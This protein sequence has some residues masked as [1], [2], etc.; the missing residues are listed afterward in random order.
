MAVARLA[1]HGDPQVVLIG[2][3][4]SLAA[5]ESAWMLLD[6]GYDV[7][8]FT[9]SGTRPAIGRDHRITIRPITSPQDDARTAVA[10]LIALAERVTPS[11]VLPLDDD[12][13]V[14]LTGSDRCRFQEGERAK[15]A[16]GTSYSAARASAG[17][18]ATLEATATTFASRP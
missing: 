1:Q 10:D 18:P 6:A 7:I 14:R 8:A 15:T 9:R 11:A 17:T 16:L 4:E 3:A 2:F 5:I 12:A 13:V